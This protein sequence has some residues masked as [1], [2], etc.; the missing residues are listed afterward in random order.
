MRREDPATAAIALAEAFPSL[1]YSGYTP[2]ELPKRDAKVLR[3]MA[4][5]IARLDGKV[6]ASGPFQATKPGMRALNVGWAIATLREL[7]AQ[8][9]N[10]PVLEAELGE[11]L[12]HDKD[13]LA[14]ALKILS[15]LAA[16]D[17]MGSAR[18]YAALARIR[19]QTGDAAGSAEAAKR[20][21]TM[22]KTPTICP[23]VPDSD[24]TKVAQ[25]GA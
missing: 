16:K 14:E 23:A 20:C 22:T 5:A 15:R 1:R 2:A 19:Q 10:D 9:P 4:L 18:G 6:E 3:M 13:Q 11:A 12:A 17:V 7:N 24:A 21:R 25:T 8:R